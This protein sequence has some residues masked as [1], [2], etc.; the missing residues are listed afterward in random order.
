M[1]IRKTLS[2]IVVTWAITG[3]ATTG[4]TAAPEQASKLKHDL[5]EV[6][7]QVRAIE[8]RI[9][10]TCA[11]MAEV[12]EISVSKNYEWD[13]ALTGDRVTSPTRGLSDGAK[14]SVA[15][16]NARATFRNMDI[17]AWKRIVFNRSGLNVVP[18]IK[19]VAKGRAAYA[20]LDG[21]NEQPS[22]RRAPIIR[23]DNAQIEYLESP[24]RFE[25]EAQT[26]PG[27]PVGR[28]DRL[29]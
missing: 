18:F 29:R 7:Q 25:K 12:V 6:P 19:I 16:G 24:G 4:S 22:I 23:I 15:E 28:A 2:A 26:P 9:D 27:D 5:S 11:L 1:I 21:G 20:V 17:R 10:E 3:C 13:V 14:V 8:R